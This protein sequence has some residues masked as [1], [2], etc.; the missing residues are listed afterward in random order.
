M[1]NWLWAGVIDVSIV[2]LSDE[3]LGYIFRLAELFNRS[4]NQR[5]KPPPFI[6]F[7]IVPPWPTVYPVLASGK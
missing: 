5:G 2:I 6:V 3:G 1:D 7:N 4:P